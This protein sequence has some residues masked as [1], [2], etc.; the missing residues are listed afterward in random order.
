M[1]FFAGSLDAH[2]A[3]ETAPRCDLNLPRTKP[4]LFL[5]L[6]QYIEDTHVLQ[7]IEEGTNDAGP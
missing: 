2:G 1:P 7:S 3:L 5:I 6:F 4:F